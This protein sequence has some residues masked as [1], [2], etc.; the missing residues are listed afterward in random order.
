MRFAFAGID[1]LGDVFETLLA[2]GWEPVKLFTR[3]CDNI[4]DFN[5]VTVSRARAL[6]LPIQTSRLLPADLA[7]LKAMGCQALVVAGYPWLITGWERHL[8][9]A[10]NFHPSPLPMGR[11]PYPLFQAILDAYPEWGIAAH[12]LAP[13]FDTGAIVAQR[14][15]G[16]SAAETHDT[17]LAKCQMAAKSIASELADDLPRLW[18]E[19]KPQGPG[20]YWPR[21]T[22]AQRTVD[23]TKGV[24]D[25]LRTI[26]AFGSIE[27]FAQI[28][29]RYVYVWEATGWEEPHR[30]R[31]GSLIHR[32]RKHMVIA[33]GNGFVQVTGWSPYAPG[34]SRKA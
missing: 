12:V 5:D 10:V 30:Y 20:S 29:S 6:R 22:Q 14:R 18:H 2:R 17:L 19:A 31:P 28:D 1:F 7:G 8:P 23:W 27:A 26:R 4:Y 24:Q 9:Y 32:H 34:P 13:S 33:A 15:F 25:A 21:I 16:L 3:P 11:G